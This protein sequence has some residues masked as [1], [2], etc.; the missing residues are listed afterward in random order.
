MNSTLET[1]NEH[2]SANEPSWLAERRAAGLD[3]FKNLAMPTA[4]DE[5]WRF[6]SVGKLSIDNF[7]P[8]AAPASTTLDA[9]T[10][11]SELVTTRAGRSVYVDDAPANFEGVSPEL[12]AQGVVYLPLAEAIEQHPELL[13]KYFLK[14]STELGSEK[15]FGLHA[16]TV[17]AGSLLYVPKGVEI[18]EPFVNYYWTSATRSAVFPHTLIIAEDNS[19]V[20][21]VD[22]FFS[23]TDANEALNIS[24]SNIHAGA[25]AHVFRKIVQD[26]NEKTVSF[27]LD[28]TVAE[29]DAQVQNVAVNIGAERAR[30]ESQ[31]RIE[32]PGAD[33]KMYSLTVAE[34]TQEFDQRT[35]QTHNAPNAVSDLLY[36]NALLNNARS[37]FS[38]LI[39]V[40]EGAQQTD[41]YQ[42]NRN[43][44][45]DPTAEA[46][47]LPGLE[48]LA[49]DVR[50]SHG[51]T[52][53][54]V[55]EAEL[56]Y[57]MQRGISRRVAMQLMVFGFFEEIIEKIDN[58]ELAENLRQLIHKKFESK[59]K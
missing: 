32:G 31:T 54:N 48:I 7:N 50:C 11:R 18:A 44:L 55:D 15:F 19:K 6:A 29:R 33:V 37:I 34:E 51:A 57:M 27:Q 13:K 59:I 46:N 20:S 4:R 28:T 52:T 47:A 2:L 58:D 53:G 38:G 10:E 45:L 3:R 49:N 56:F 26:W 8:V 30:F 25:N 17:K 14:E 24:V 35:Y 16:A 12:L 21:V 23:E 5:A 40:A 1:A 9:L 43:L 41:A 22:L 39:K 36:K 42:T